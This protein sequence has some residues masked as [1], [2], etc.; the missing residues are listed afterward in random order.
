MES[1]HQNKQEKHSEVPRNCEEKKLY[2]KEIAIQGM[3]DQG[4]VK[5]SDWNNYGIPFKGVT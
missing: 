1:T 5:K 4:E 3:E 2:I